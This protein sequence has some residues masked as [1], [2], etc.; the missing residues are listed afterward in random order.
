MKTSSMALLVACCAVLATLGRPHCLP[1]RAAEPL[2]RG[3]IT[4]I[5][6]TQ[7][8]Q[9][10]WH[11]RVFFSSDWNSLIVT[12]DRNKVR[13]WD[14]TT[15]E[16]VHEIEMPNAQFNGADFAPSSGL[17]AVIGTQRPEELPAT[18]EQIQQTVWLIDTAT[19]Q[20]VHTLPMKGSR[21]A[22]FFRIQFTPDAK[23]LV[24]ALDDEIRVWDVKTGDELIRLKVPAQNKL[25]AVSS[26][27]K[28]IAYGAFDVYLW[29]WEA[30][31]EPKKF[32]GIGNFGMDLAGSRCTSS[33][34]RAAR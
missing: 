8:R 1:V 10:S 23:R 25:L 18:I 9:V 19:R 13:W 20:V 15:G 4:R 32:A 16:R 34:K 14:P 22:V 33:H 5:G 21:H 12:D 7:F 6:T 2:P 11:K 3:A 17:L 28:A 31:D 26:D 30:G 24:T 27:G 29:R